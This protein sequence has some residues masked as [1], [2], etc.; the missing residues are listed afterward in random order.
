MQAVDNYIISEDDYKTSI[1]IEESV[2]REI[3]KISDLSG[4]NVFIVGGY[5]RD[6]IL[7]RPRSDFDFTVEG[8]CFKFAETLAKHFHSKAVFYQRFR[9]AMVPIGKYKC[10]FVGTRK[11]EYV[12]SSRNPKVSEGTL[13]EDIR[14]RDFT[15]NTL[16]AK[17][18]GEKESRILDIFDG[19]GDIKRKLIRTPLDPVITFSEDPLRIMRAARFASQLNFTLDS[20][21]IDAAKEISE[22]I[23]II[24]M[25]RISDELI[26]ILNSPKPSVGFELLSQ[27]QVLDIIWPELTRLKG[28]EKRTVGKVDFR[29]KDIFRHTMKVLDKV[30]AVSDNTWLR[31]AAL[32]HD[33]AKPQT[34]HFSPDIGWSFHGHEEIGARKVADIF[35]RLKL[36]FEYIPYVEKLVRLH[37]RPMA[38]V[39]NTITDSAIRRLAFLAGDAL[40]DLFTLCRADITTNNPLLTE[41]YLN[42]YEIVRKKILDVQDKDK[43]REFQSPVRGEE[44]MEICNISPSISVGLI[45]SAI[46]EAILDGIIANEYEP[47]MQYFLTNKDKWLEEIKS[48]ERH[49]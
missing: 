39:D 38:L 32:I 43:L 13:Y 1:S 9:T 16:A 46:E 42:N 11:E 24:S 15:I 6:W 4:I 17:I 35:K 2:I 12:S 31:F 26:K 49:K 33:I 20:K 14:R 5:V 21:L 29:H 48:G 19:L 36:P 25:E 28:D 41:Q 8:D 45:K 44:I 27:M 22:R 47:A 18:S 30:A 23:R 7:G 10:E 3:G 40:D 34:K 37:Q